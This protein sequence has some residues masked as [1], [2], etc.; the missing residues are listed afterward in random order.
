VKIARRYRHHPDPG[1]AAI[2]AATD[3]LSHDLRQALEAI[4]ST[5]KL[6]H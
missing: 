4:N 6:A 5:C 1:R 3:R 2:I